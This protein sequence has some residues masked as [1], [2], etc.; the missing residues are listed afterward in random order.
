MD[1]IEMIQSAD[2]V[3]YIS[4]YVDLELKGDEY[5]G[6]SPFKDEK[7]PSFSVRESPPFF[8][9]YSSGIGGNILTFIKEYH[10]VSTRDAL[11]IV[12]KFV[13]CTDDIEKPREK[14]AATII[15]KKF[16]KPKTSQ[17]ANTSVVL[18]NNIMERYEKRQDKLELWK[19]EGISDEAL[20]F[21]KVHYDPFSNR[22]VYPIF[23]MSGQIVN[24]GGRTLDPNYK[25]LGLRKY[26]YFYPWGSMNTVYG[27]FENMDDI[28]K[29]G[30]VIVFEGCKSVLIARSWGIKNTCALLTSHVNP[31]QMKIFARLGCRVVFALD[32]DIDICMDKNIDKLKSYVRVEYLHDTEGLLGEKDAPVDRGLEV[33]SKLYESRRR[34]EK[35]K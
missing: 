16:Q 22:L 27:V 4:K 20:D 10:R 23:N 34:L 15:S 31:N 29:C 8:Y 13:G 24:I 18:P 26:T 21:F 12:K 6:L 30:E 28:K 14:M 17:K 2:I 7:T 11:E 33:F 9:D 1:L 19:S 3:E 25:Q 35:I 32:R 5:W